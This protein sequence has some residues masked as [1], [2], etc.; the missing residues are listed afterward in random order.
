MYRY[1]QRVSSIVDEVWYTFYKSLYKLYG[2]VL[3]LPL[4]LEVQFAVTD[5]I[6]QR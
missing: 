1:L 5:F 6:Y 3:L 2:W 4:Q